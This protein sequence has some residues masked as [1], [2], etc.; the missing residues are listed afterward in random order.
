MRLLLDTHIV[1][2]AAAMPEKLPNTAVELLNDERNTLFFSA[3]SFW[4]IV[5][6]NALGRSDFQVNC[7]QLRS[8]L[9]IN[10]Y[11]ELLVSSEH[12]LYVETLPSH[13]KDPFDR[14]LVAQ[15]IVEDMTLLTAD[16]LLSQYPSVL[17]VS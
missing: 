14:I 12:C 7:Q 9:L 2:W 13:H 4:E 8:G 5:I 3:A 1:L 16:S 17:L 6:K 11:H 10:N 15:A